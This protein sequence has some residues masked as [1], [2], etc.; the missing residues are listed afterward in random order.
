M[1]KRLGKEYKLLDK[2]ARVEK[3]RTATA[4]KFTTYLRGLSEKDKEKFK[5]YL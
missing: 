4:L 3:L 5:L 1:E 2:D